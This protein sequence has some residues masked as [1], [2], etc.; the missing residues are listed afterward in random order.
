[1]SKIKCL[2]TPHLI[3][4]KLKNISKQEVSYLPTYSGLYLKRNIF[5]KKFFTDIIDLGLHFDFC[6]NESYSTF[7]AKAGFFLHAKIYLRN[8]ELFTNW[9]CVI[10]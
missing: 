7:V 8:N 4:V 2:K 3:T 6:E 5:K 1:M 10:K 9:K